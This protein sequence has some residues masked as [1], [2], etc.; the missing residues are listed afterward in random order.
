ME[1]MTLFD[2]ETLERA[3][4]LDKSEK[5][6]EEILI[7]LSFQV[8]GHLDRGYIYSR[9]EPKI[10]PIGE[11]SLDIHFMIRKPAKYT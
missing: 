4:A 6:S 5:Y 7:W 3:L 8:Q 10:T 9:V 11:D 1:G 2:Q